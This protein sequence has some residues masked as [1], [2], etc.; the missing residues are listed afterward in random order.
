MSSVCLCLWYNQSPFCTT[1]VC[2]SLR[3]ASPVHLS[4]IC[5]ATFLFSIFFS[6]L[7]FLTLLL[8][9]CRFSAFFS[10]LFFLLPCHKADFVISTVREGGR[11]GRTCHCLTFAAAAAALLCRDRQADKQKAK[12]NKNK[13]WQPFPSFLFFPL[14]TFTFL[15]VHFGL[16]I[17]SSPA[18][19]LAVAQKLTKADRE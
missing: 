1:T 10:L 19:A 18:R 13:S 5:N 12:G 17:S 3:S 2:L 7:L 14:L 9:F 4:P 6:V 11:E 15:A 16:C 8:F